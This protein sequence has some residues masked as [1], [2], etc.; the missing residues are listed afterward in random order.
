S[1]GMD[2]QK[3][4]VVSGCPVFLWGVLT[5]GVSGGSAKQGDEAD[6]YAFQGSMNFLIV[7][8][9]RVL[10]KSW[11]VHPPKQPNDNFA[12]AG[13]WSTP[14]VDRA[15]KVAYVGSANPFKPQAEHKHANSVLKFD[16]DPKSPHFG[17]I[18]GS[19]KGLVDEYFPQ[20][21][22]MPCFDIP[23]NPPPYYPQG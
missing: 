3:S 4:C 14:A 22:Q 2:A 13:I 9:G 19:Y 21:S 15:E 18:V 20:L 6:R 12:G 5:S 10:R 16:V 8:D 7:D 17:E 11:T 1:N 23:G